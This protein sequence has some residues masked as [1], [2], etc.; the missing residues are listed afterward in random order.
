MSN[1]IAVIAQGRHALS[2]DEIPRRD[3]DR[4]W[5]GLR[6][7]MPC[8]I[9]AKRVTVSQMEYALQFRQDGATPGL[10]R[11]HLH[12]RCFAAWQMERTKLE[13]RR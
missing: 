13:D 1:E 3:A 7:D 4:T 11:Y 6:A 10:D 12:L 9:C 5:G 2:G 8:T